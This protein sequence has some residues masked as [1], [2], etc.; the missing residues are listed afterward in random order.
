[1]TKLTF[2]VLDYRLISVNSPTPLSY[3]CLSTVLVVVVVVVVV[4]LVVVVVV[5]V[6]VAVMA[7]SPSYLVTNRQ[8]ASGGEPQSPGDHAGGRHACRQGAARQGD[9]GS[10][11]KGK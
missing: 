8:G 1:M 6:E 4:L 7:C 11:H 2:P 5:V 10:E 3:F 9:G